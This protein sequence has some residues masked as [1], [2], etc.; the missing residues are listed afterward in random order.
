MVFVENVIPV[1]RKAGLSDI[2]TL[3][4]LR[5]ELLAE[6]NH[7][8]AFDRSSLVNKTRMYFL[9]KVP[10]NKFIAWLAEINDEIVGTSGL[11]FFERPPL[12]ENLSGIEAYIMNMYTLRNWRNR[13]IATLLL[14]EVISFVKTTP[15]KKVWLHA[16]WNA[17]S[18]YERFG[19][20]TLSKDM[21]STVEME[22]YL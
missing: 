21:H 10:S 17:K 8:I 1:I 12:I 16:T 7:D 20:T 19:F 13:G 6:I 22:Y 15:A 9:E 4:K 14:K 11:V 5:I 2:E 18:L 3:V